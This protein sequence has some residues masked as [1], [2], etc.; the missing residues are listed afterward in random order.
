EIAAKG[1]TL[2]WNPFWPGDSL[3]EHFRVHLSLFPDGYYYQYYGAGVLVTP[4]V[5]Y[6]SVLALQFLLE[7]NWLE[8]RS[9][10]EERA[11]ELNDSD[12][13]Y[14]QGWHAA[15]RLSLEVTKFSL[16]VGAGAFCD[17][18]ECAN[19]L[20]PAYSAGFEVIFGVAGGGPLTPP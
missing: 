7:K 3:N 10:R 16:Y 13:Q 2:S 18:I 15:A 12:L 4:P 8:V 5:V 17:Q 1:A 11:A 20:E 9:G 6:G 14:I 19:T